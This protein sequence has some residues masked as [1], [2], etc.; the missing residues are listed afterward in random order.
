VPIINEIDISYD[1]KRQDAANP[2]NP[3]RNASVSSIDHSDSVLWQKLMKPVTNSSVEHWL[4]LPYVVYFW[5]IEES[6]SSL[7]Q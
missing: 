2:Y 5:A 4:A 3:N 7:L 1:N 6:A